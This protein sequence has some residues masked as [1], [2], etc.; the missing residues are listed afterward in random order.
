MK[1]RILKSTA[2]VL[3]TFAALVLAGC[4]TPPSANVQP[5][6]KPGLIQDGIAVQSV[7]NP[8]TVQAIDVG[9]RTI[10]L[11]LSD[12]TTPTYQVGAQVKNFDR[13]QV[14]NQ[15]RAT[16]TDVLAVYRLENG[17]LPDGA[18]AETLGVNA[19]VLKVDPSYRILTLQYPDGRSE[20]L[21][22][23]LGTRMQ[24]M[25]PGDSVVARP[26]EVTAINIQKP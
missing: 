10:T 11:K 4:W 3:I 1:M 16:V 19:R 8:A 5:A 25:A 2:L 22:P 12:N 24:E 17:R 14:G 7:K 23:G 6:G 21:K 26:Q 20:K 18:T 13:V 9:A 15:V